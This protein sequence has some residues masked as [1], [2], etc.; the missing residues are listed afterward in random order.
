[1]KECAKLE[2]QPT[3]LIKD[4]ERSNE[5]SDKL[6]EFFEANK[7]V[8]ITS[9]SNSSVHKYFPSKS[10]QMEVNFEW[11]ELNEEE[12]NR[13][14]KSEITFQDSQVTLGALL[15]DE[16]LEKAPLDLFFDPSKLKLQIF[17][18]S[19][20]KEGL[21]FI[22][23][24]YESTL[25]SD[26][27]VNYTSED[28]TELAEKQKIVLISDV[29]GMGKSTSAAHLA[30]DFKRKNPLILVVFVDLKQHTKA[31][32]KDKDEQ[33]FEEINQ[34]F[35]SKKLLNFPNNFEQEI[36][37][38]FYDNGKVHF[39]IDGFDEISP[40]YKLFVKTILKAV[41]Y[42]GNRLLV[43]TRPHLAEKLEEELDTKAFRLLP[44]SYHDQ[45]QVLTKYWWF[46]S[47]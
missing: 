13:I 40:D 4:S 31:F 23:R 42:S 34:S 41:R 11:K 45:I 32:S 29:A 19:L 2:V 35:F 7:I 18:D 22:K 28:F 24:R 37:K 36:F 15:T 16:L 10:N 17:S 25:K 20:P 30:R 6:K 38:H 8:F 46:L 43:T 5:S 47:I 39:V 12:K 26:D 1:L 27:K 9:R 21:V 33:K 14:R 3:F 44:F